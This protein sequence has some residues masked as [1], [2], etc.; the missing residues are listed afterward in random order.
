MRRDLLRPRYDLPGLFQHHQMQK[1][2]QLW[3]THNLSHDME[4][5]R[6]ERTSERCCARD[7]GG[8]G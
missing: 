7:G 3:A 8:A 4:L 2:I 6:S 5:A 1:M